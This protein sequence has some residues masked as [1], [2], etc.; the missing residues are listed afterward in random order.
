M[1]TST[2]GQDDLT[3]PQ[4]P[5]QSLGQLV[6]ELTTEMRT[7]VQQE[8]QLAKV[9]LKEE[10]ARAGKGGGMLGGGAFAGYIA[11]LLLSFAAAWGIATAINTGIAFLIVG[12]VWALIAGVLA[13]LGRTQ[14]KRVNVKPEQTVETVQEDVQWAKNQR[15]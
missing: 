3:Q 7:L 9:E 10:A 2:P 4:R 12:A 1:E 6:G 11:I 14:L 15:K 8:V 5:D 13:W